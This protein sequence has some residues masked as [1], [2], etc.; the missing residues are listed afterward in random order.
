MNRAF[1]QVPRSLTEPGQGDFWA[2][3]DLTAKEPIYL[4]LDLPS[5]LKL[6]TR[7]A[8][9]QALLERLGTAFDTFPLPTT[10]CTD[11]DLISLCAC[12]EIAL[13]SSNDDEQS[14]RE[15]VIDVA[16]AIIKVRK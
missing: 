4:F 5:L 11:S 6:K 10:T 8:P 16:P 14:L 15:Q 12:V 3:D 7:S 2:L 1:K 13:K 9:P